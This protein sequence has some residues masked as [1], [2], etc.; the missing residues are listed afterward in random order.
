MPGAR[1]AQVHELW[2]NHQSVIGERGLR[3]LIQLYD[4]EREVRGL[5]AAHRNEYDRSNP[6]PLDDAMHLW[7]L[8][9]RRKLPEASATIKAIEHSLK[10]WTALTRY[11][12]DGNLPGDNNWV[13]NQIRRSAP[14]AH[15]PRIL[16][17]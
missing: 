6:R 7:L 8:E 2:V 3:F 10:R 17:P 4:I 13:E 14:R 15:A 11:I 5:D 9:Q 16:W 12:D 1:A